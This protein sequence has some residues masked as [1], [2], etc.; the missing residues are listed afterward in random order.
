M[1]EVNNSLML[2]IWNDIKNG[3]T[4]LYVLCFL[5]FMYFIKPYMNNIIGF[6][7]NLIKGKVEKKTKEYTADDVRN[8]P[9]FKDLDFWLDVGIKSLKM[10]NININYPLTRVVHQESEDYL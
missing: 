10:N 7:G 3:G 5:V 1:E 4:S 8:H 2:A 6:L 9:I